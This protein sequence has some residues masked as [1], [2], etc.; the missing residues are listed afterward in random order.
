MFGYLIAQLTHRRSRAVV[1][2]VGVLL[3]SV[4]F[5]LLTATT[6]TSS[7]RV[8]GTVQTNLRPVYDLLVR[9]PGSQSEIER[10]QGLVRNNFET[11]LSGGITDTQ[12][13]AIRDLPGVEVAAPVEYVGWVMQPVSALLPAG[14]HMEPDTLYR[15]NVSYSANT[16]STYPLGAVDYLYYAS[17]PNGCAGMLIHPP[18]QEHVLDQTPFLLCYDPGRQGNHLASIE[19]IEI[20]RPLYVPFLVVCLANR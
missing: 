1:T 11:G 2:A 19:D 6:R 12:L 10:E 5:V 17:K 4:S 18:P 7:A 15:L 3:A 9:P 8:Q 20:G 13:D 14:H 16:A